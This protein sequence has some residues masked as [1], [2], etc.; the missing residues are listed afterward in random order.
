MSKIK[1]AVLSF[2]ASSILIVIIEAIIGI[3]L[4]VYYWLNFVSVEI[5]DAF[6]PLLPTT[7]SFAESASNIIFMTKI[8]SLFL[9]FMSS[10]ALLIA[11]IV[12]VLI[13][14]EREY[15]RYDY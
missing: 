1:Y 11:A 15:Q 10:P 14:D 7:G 3:P 2:I 12:Y 13:P 6:I 5:F 4:S 8:L 9:R